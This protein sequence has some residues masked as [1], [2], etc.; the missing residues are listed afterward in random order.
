MSRCAGEANLSTIEVILVDNASEDGS[1]ALIRE[2]YPWVKLIELPENRGFTG[3][4]NAGIAASEGEV[5]ALLNNDT[6]VDPNWAEAVMDAFARHSEVGSVASKMLLFDKRDHLH[7]AG[8]TFSRDGRAGNRG[9]WQRDVGQY[10]TEEYVFSACGGSSAY[11]RAMLD[12]IGVLDDTFFFLMEDVDLGWRAQLAGWRC[13][14]ARAV[15]YH[16]LGDW[17]RRD[18]E[19]LRRP[20][21]THSSRQNL[22]AALWRRYGGLILRAQVKE[23]WNAL[24][25]WRGKAARA[26]LRMLAGVWRALTIWPQRRR[27]QATR[28]VSIEY[29]DSLLLPPQS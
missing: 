8:D 6:E 11:R 16:H 26:R 29:L 14:Y 25:A 3:A 10:D 7:T 20:Q 1:Q 18:G 9:V 27:V 12:Q 28:T 5:V 15:V 21:H 2:Q 19:L 22:P 4:C 13:L 23:G 17:R 24:R